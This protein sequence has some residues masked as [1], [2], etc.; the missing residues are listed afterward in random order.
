MGKEI[1]KELEFYDG[2]YKVSNL[3]R[4][5]STCRKKVVTLKPQVNNCWY[6][7]VMLYWYKKHN[8]SFVHRLVAQAFIQNPDNKP[9][10]NHINWIKT[11][12]RVENLEWCTASENQLHSYK[13]L[14]RDNNFRTNHPRTNLWK[15]WKLSKISKR[16]WQYNKEMTLIKVW[17]SAMDVQR[18]LWVGHS[19]I[20]GVC[21]WKRKTSRWFIWRFIT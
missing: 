8:F 15:F 14:W 4:V 21:N 5:N 16:V 3:W 6:Y 2:K 20:C 9:E 12:N 18:E 7:R 13:K 11:D 10:V 19:Q 1:F 17:Y